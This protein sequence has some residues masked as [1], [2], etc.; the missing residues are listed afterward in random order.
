MSNI[1]AR[2]HYENEL[3]P[4]RETNRSTHLAA[5]RVF[6]VT[7]DDASVKATE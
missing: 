6:R 7:Q 2:K 3:K 4:G 5:R 1:D